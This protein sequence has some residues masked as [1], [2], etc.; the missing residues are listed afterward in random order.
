MTHPDLLRKPEIPNRYKI[1]FDGDL[2]FSIT[3]LFLLNLLF[4]VFYSV[5]ILLSDTIHTSGLYTA[6]QNIVPWLSYWMDTVD[7]IEL[8]VMTL[9]MPVYLGIGLLITKKIYFNTNFLRNVWIQILC[10]LSVTAFFIFRFITYENSLFTDNILVVLF[11]TLFL[12]LGII[13]LNK[14]SLPNGFKPVLLFIFFAFLCVVG[15]L[16]NS[17]ASV[18]DYS[19]YIGP[20][21]KILQG[22][23]P[24]TFYMQY[25][26][27]GTYLFSWMQL[28]HLKLHEMQIVLIFIFA[29]W[30][31]LYR[32]AALDLFHSKTYAFLFVFVLII[33]RCFAISDGPVS[34]PQVSV[35]RL[36]LWVPLLLAVVGFGFNSWKTAAAFSAMYLADDIFGLM[37]LGLYIFILFIDFLNPFFTE[38]KHI[39]FPE[40]IKLLLPVL[41]ALMVHYI[42]FGSFGSASGKM[43]SNLHLG[44]LP[45]SKYSSFWIIAW[46]LPICFY[47]LNKTIKNKPLIFFIIG[48]TC[49]Q[50]IYF[51]GRSH[52][53]NLLN[54]SGIFVF[55]LFLTLDLLYTHSLSKKNML[56]VTLILIACIGINYSTAIK[57]KWNLALNKIQTHTIFEPNPI[58][59]ELAVKGAYLK[60]LKYDKIMIISEA[61]SYLNYRLGYPQ[62]GYFS[63]FCANVFIDETSAFLKNQLNS[64]YHLIVFP[65]VDNKLAVGILSLNKAVNREQFV[66]SALK[67]GLVEVKWTGN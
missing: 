28:L 46:L 27:A 57:G 65:V 22:E 56:F 25:N 62:T 51:F 52:D 58:E 17:P 39:L 9:A 67:Y 63:P 34:I 29:F 26:L 6:K 40:K 38:K 54:I 14:I 18:F 59:N 44:F 5:F 33:V 3:H 45:I 48:V 2:K 24:G 47:I 61:D 50:L 42:I 43:Y 13:R 66:A 36:D 20:A 1:F 23:M 60:S 31:L 64:G 15:L 16:I 37:Y 11:I 53:H 21:N 32:K 19:Y 4:V 35:I 41:I 49:I 10:L 7:G 8:N 12:S 55:I 30:I